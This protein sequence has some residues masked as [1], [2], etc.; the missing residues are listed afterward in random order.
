MTSHPS[1]SEE[2]RLARVWNS[3]PVVFLLRLSII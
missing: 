1:A 2:E 3:F